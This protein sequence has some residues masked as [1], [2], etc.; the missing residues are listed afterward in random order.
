MQTCKSDERVVLRF[1]IRDSGIGMSPEQTERLFQAFSQVDSSIT[2]RFGGTGLGL[3]LSKGLVE[4]MG[5]TIEVE[6]RLGRGSTFSFT[7]SLEPAP[8]NER[9]REIL[10]GRSALVVGEDGPNH[11]LMEALLGLEMN[12]HVEPTAEAALLYVQAHPQACSLAFVHFVVQGESGLAALR[13]LGRLPQLRIVLTADRKDEAALSALDRLGRSVLLKPFTRSSLLDLLLE[14]VGPHPSREACPPQAGARILLVEDNPANQRITCE[15]L[16]QEGFQ[17]DVASNGREA[18]ERVLVAPWDCPWQLILM[19]L[20]MPEMDGFAATKAIRAEERFHSLPIVALTAHVLPEERERCRLVGMNDFLGKPVDPKKLFATLRRWLPVSGDARRVLVVDDN[21]TNQLIAQG[22]LEQAG[23]SVDV[24]NNGKE[25]VERILACS[26]P[27]PWAVVLMDVEMPEMD[28][29]AATVRIRQEARF[30]TLPIVAMTGHV[31]EEEKA[32]CLQAGMDDYLTKPL[33]PELLFSKLRRWIFPNPPAKPTETVDF[34]SLEEVDTVDGLMRVGG[35]AT[36]YR[37][38]LLGLAGRG[39]DLQIAL[40]A[41]LQAGDRKKLEILSH[42]LKG[43][44][45]SLGMTS[46][47]LAAAAVEQAVRRLEDCQAT[48]GPLLETLAR[49][50][51]RVLA[52]L[53]AE[54]CENLPEVAVDALEAIQ[55]LQTWLE[56]SDGRAIEALPP[57][58]QAAKAWAAQGQLERLAEL[59]GQFDSESALGVLQEISRSRPGSQ[60]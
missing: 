34:P 53:P 51:P 2:R 7:C 50:C 45:S 28:G 20:Q 9:E 52:T 14:L 24:A 8:A 48:T 41:A 57:V 54:T 44:A 33:E 23:F 3:A 55:N 15:L 46:L 40:Q 19:D 22:L 31:F 39:A 13:E 1:Q 32:R 56:N 6:S 29:C 36:L 30:R 12:V 58:L 21:S 27:C 59:V 26:Q 11:N 16:G 37:S 43:E 17:V 47:A 35:N 5:G 10:A 49:V 60:L 4:Q 42:S 18:V 25:A 38:L